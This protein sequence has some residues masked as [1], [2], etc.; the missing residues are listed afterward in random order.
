[1]EQTVCLSLQ[2][3]PYPLLFMV[4][5][6][7]TREATTRFLIFLLSRILLT[8]DLSIPL[9]MVSIMTTPMDSFRILLRKEVVLFIPRMAM[10]I[11]MYPERISIHPFLSIPVKRSI[12][13]DLI[14]PIFLPLVRLLIRV[15]PLLLRLNSCLYLFLFLFSIP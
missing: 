14:L 2:V 5:M 13:N 15:C 9:I 12:Q 11:L 8:F 3:V 4:M 1:M 10:S 6:L 7:P